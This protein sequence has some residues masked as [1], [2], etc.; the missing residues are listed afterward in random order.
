MQND[1]SFFRRT[2]ILESVWAVNPTGNFEIDCH[3]GHTLAQEFLDY[4][5]V[6]LLG[7]IVKQ[8]PPQHTGI[9]IGF[10]SAVAG[11]A[12]G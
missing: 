6:G 1:P 8:M 2:A 4:R 7:Q 5:Q 9:E 11:A 10:L 3:K 12:I